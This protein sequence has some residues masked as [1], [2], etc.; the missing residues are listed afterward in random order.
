MEASIAEF[1]AEEELI[2]I[3]PKVEIPVMHL[4]TVT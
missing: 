3:V 1:L 4:H 2:E